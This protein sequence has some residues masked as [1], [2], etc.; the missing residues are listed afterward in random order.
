MSKHPCRAF[1]KSFG[2]STGVQCQL[3]CVPHRFA[4]ATLKC[5][6]LYV[7]SEVSVRAVPTVALGQVGRRVQ[8]R[9]AHVVAVPLRADA[10]LLHPQVSALHPRRSVGCHD[11]RVLV[12]QAAERPP[13]AGILGRR[14][15]R[16]KRRKTRVTPEKNVTGLRK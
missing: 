1:R 11:G 14:P 3:L 5:P 8:V 12:H 10:A 7:V 6:V 2:R 16:G 9:A 15:I 13:G 4:C